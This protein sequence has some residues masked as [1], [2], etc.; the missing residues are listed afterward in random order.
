[1][2][3]YELPASVAPDGYDALLCD[4][5]QGFCVYTQHLDVG[6]SS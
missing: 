4:H 6:Q 3:M 5:L 1:M 2:S